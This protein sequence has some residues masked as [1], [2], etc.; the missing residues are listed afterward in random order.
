MSKAAMASVIIPTYNRV[1]RLRRVL[2]AFA[3]Q[4]LGSTHFEVIVVSDGSTDGT[5][6]F[7]R[8]AIT[9]F[10]LVVI[11][12]P[13]AGPA[14]ARNAGVRRATGPLLLFIDDD[15]VPQ[16][17]L[18]EQ[19]LVTHAR[20][21]AEAVVIGPMLT[22]PDHHPSA[23]VQWEQAMLYKQYDAM[24]QG[25][26]EA[27]H[28]QF[29]T[30]NASVGRDFFLATGGFDERFR[31][32]EDVELAYR[33]HNSGATFIF[34]PRAVGFHYA[35]R[36][37]SSWIDN[38]TAYGRN[39]VLFDRYHG[40]LNRLKAARWEFKGR[41]PVVR[42]LTQRCVGRPR[43]EHSV[44]LAGRAMASVGHDLRLEAPMLMALSAVYNTA[45]YSG[46][47][48]ALGGRQEFA[49]FLAVLKVPASLANAWATESA[50]TT[51]TGAAL[52]A[53]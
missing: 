25:R 39:D 20:A 6:E 13:N 52:R 40:Q 5:D 27:T 11:A 46:M 28:R 36:S 23:F 9:P 37:F 51:D 16:P 3:A 21:G 10:R 12:R 22:P 43:L 1:D 7:L 30:G 38:A 32:A 26:Y 2:D 44:H 33:L 35:E 41:H 15:V 8:H 47:A 50:Q 34:D 53:L 17:Q 18:V 14:S 29:Y 42:W 48:N 45:Y 49:E 4:T 31:R 24:M 19:H